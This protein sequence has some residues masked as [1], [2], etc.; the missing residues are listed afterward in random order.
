MALA[1]LILTITVSLALAVTLFLDLS[2]LRGEVAAHRATRVV[3]LQPE[4]AAAAELMRLT[5]T[6]QLEPLVLGPVVKET[7]EETAQAQILGLTVVAGVAV[8]LLLLVVLVGLTGATAATEQHRQSP[9]LR[10][11]TLVAVAVVLLL[12]ALPVLVALVVEVQAV[13]GRQ[14]PGPQILAVVAAVVAAVVE[15]AAPAL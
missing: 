15:V 7:L 14:L 4:V 11:H 5:Q 2:P 6:Q 12:M 3:R 13:P 1:A 9:D 10:L 8:A